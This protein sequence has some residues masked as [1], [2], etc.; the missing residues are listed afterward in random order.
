MART[1]WETA[2][3]VP[4]RSKGHG[5]SSGRRPGSWQIELAPGQVNRRTVPAGTRS[6]GNYNR[7]FIKQGRTDYH[8][9]IRTVDGVRYLYIWRDPAPE[10]H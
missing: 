5:R 4:E 1:Q 6:V 9:A 2:E 8:A 10:V 3:S 7:N